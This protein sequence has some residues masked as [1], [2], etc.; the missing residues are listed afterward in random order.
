MEHERWCQ[1]L[2]V[3]SLGGLVSTCPT[4]PS[5]KMYMSLGLWGEVKSTK[6]CTC[7]DYFILVP[8]NEIFS[9]DLAGKFEEV[10][11]RSFHVLQ[12]SSGSGVSWNGQVCILIKQTEIYLLVTL[13]STSDHHLLWHIFSFSHRWRDQH[14]HKRK[15]TR[16]QSGWRTHHSGG[17]GR[18]GCPSRG[19][20]GG[21][22]PGRG[23]GAQF[24]LPRLRGRAAAVP[25]QNEERTDAPQ[26]PQPAGG[27]GLQDRTVQSHNRLRKGNLLLHFL[28]PIWHCLLKENESNNG[29]HVQNGHFPL[30]NE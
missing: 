4:K 29:L 7:G 19:G 12:S 23:L 9:N 3:S 22:V 17:D 14:N 13:W 5:S 24:E 6:H 30:Q 28:K 20:N 25:E 2:P 18:G 11:S 15:V 21:N 27:T 16:R 8:L 10:M 1:Q 26:C